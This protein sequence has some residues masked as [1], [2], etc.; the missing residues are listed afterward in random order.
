MGGRGLFARVTDER[1][2]LV[3]V[4]AYFPATLGT[5]VRQKAR[6]ITGIALVG[7]DRV[8]WA[9]PLA[10]VDHWMRMRDRRAPIAVLV[11]GAAYL[12]IVAW[13]AS[14]VSHGLTG[15]PVAPVPDAVRLLLIV[16]AWLLGWRLIVRAAFTGR[17]YGW[18]EAMWSVP[19]LV[20]GNL[21]ALLAAG[22]AIWRYI[23]MLRG[24]APAWDKTRHEFPAFDQPI[25][26]VAS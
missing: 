13:L 8:G 22:R 25:D 19:R 14:V 12:S 23:W 1:G 16:N 4:R 21:I 24:A 2:D 11:L 17:T 15:V 20:V 6:W 3:A 5:A 10:M 9:R 7:W 18:R 26:V